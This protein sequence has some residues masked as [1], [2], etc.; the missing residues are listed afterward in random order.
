MNAM[1]QLLLAGLFISSLSASAQNVIWSHAIGNWRNGPTVY[2]TPL[3][4]TSEAFTTAQL[5]A[6]YKAEYPELKNVTDLDVLRFGSTEEGEE[7]RRTL[8]AKYGMRK[9]EV[10]MLEKPKEQVVTPGPAQ[11]YRS[12]KHAHAAN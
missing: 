10:V 3:I 8:K 9:L 2:I 7:S 4:E 1:K 5:I 11:P 6:R 12:A